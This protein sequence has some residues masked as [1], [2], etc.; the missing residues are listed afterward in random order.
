MEENAT[1]RQLC[2]RPKNG[3]IS[4]QTVATWTFDACQQRLNRLWFNRDRWPAS[5]EI[6]HILTQLAELAVT[7]E[8]WAYW[9]EKASAFYGDRARQPISGLLGNRFYDYLET[10]AVDFTHH[11]WLFCRTA[12]GHESYQRREAATR[13]L[14][15]WADP[16]ELLALFRDGARGQVR[17]AAIN[18]L[19]RLSDK[20][21]LYLMEQTKDEWEPCRNAI[22]RE[23]KAILMAKA[24]T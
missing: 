4:R 2:G 18:R 23:L 3:P 16:F 12:E 24:A 14:I 7:F 11:A 19:R 6:P 5:E 21:I 22:H 17:E 10:L 1:Q 15:R 8:E 13:R 20:A 9:W